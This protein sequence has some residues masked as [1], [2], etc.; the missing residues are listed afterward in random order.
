[1]VQEISPQAAS[2]SPSQPAR[3]GRD[4][5]WRKEFPYPWDEDELVTR[6]D[7][8]RFLLAGSG[9]LFL[10]TGAL[11]ILGALPQGQSVK[12]VAVAREGE[13][14]ENQWKVFNFPDDYAQGILINLPGHGLVAYSDV[15]THLSCAVL[16]QGD[17]K[18]HCPCH[19][20]LFDAATGTVLVG[21]PT[22]PLPLIQLAR[23]G[24]KI[25]AVKEVAR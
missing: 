1:M 4:Q 3:E 20:G 18:L 12:A 11:A 19:E 16:Y 25:Y 15:C 7:T 23:Q 6:R 13:L 24:G 5:E 10:A 21:P 9:A 22:R 14:A 8:L 2:K 17:G